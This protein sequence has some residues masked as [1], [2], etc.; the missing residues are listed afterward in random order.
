MFTQKFQGMGDA[1][2]MAMKQL[3]QIVHRQAVVMSFGDAFFALSVFYVG[4]S[5]MVM[6]LEQAQ[7]SRGCRR[8]T[9][10]R[11]RAKWMPVRVKKT[12]QNKKPERLERFYRQSAIEVRP[13][14]CQKSAA[15]L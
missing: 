13:S 3:S 7:Q 2:R 1:S 10:E 8:R 15:H 11:F 12:R 9:L 6:L 14:C 4:L 5:L